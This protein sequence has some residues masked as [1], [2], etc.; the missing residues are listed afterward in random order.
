MVCV[1]I[2]LSEFPIYP[3]LSLRT[4]PVSVR[5]PVDVSTSVYLYVLQYVCVFFCLPPCCSGACT[6]LQLAGCP[7]NLS[8]HVPLCDPELIPPVAPF[9]NSSSL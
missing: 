4:L 6:C 5:L 8:Y 1:D 2:T 7:P 3:S 9:S